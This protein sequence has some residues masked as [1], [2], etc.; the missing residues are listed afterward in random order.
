MAKWSKILL[1]MAMV[2]IV[3]EWL[4]FPEEPLTEKLVESIFIISILGTIAWW[5]KRREEN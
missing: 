3:F 5:V 1:I 2:F 4:A